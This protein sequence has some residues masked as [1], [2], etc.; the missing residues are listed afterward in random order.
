M[1]FEDARP[2]EQEVVVA[3]PE[4]APANNQSMWH[5]RIAR[6]SQG[7]RIMW[8]EPMNGRG[9]RFVQL[10]EATASTQSR[11]ALQGERERLNVLNLLAPLAQQFIETGNTTA[12]GGWRQRSYAREMGKEPGDVFAGFNFPVAAW[13]GELERLQRLRGLEDEAVRA[14]I[15]PGQAG[16]ANSVYEQEVL[17]NMFP[18]I[19]VRGNANSERAASVFVNRDL[20]QARVAAAE[21]WLTQNPDLSGFEQSWQPQAENLRRELVSRYGRQFA[22]ETGSRVGASVGAQGRRNNGM[23]PRRG[24]RRTYP[25][26]AVGEWDGQGWVQVQP[27]RGQ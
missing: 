15:R 24:Q 23:A 11:E 10:S 16:T 21:Q 4:A 20:Q 7:N 8:Q 13:G 6:D 2:E 5:G 3:Q 22:S 1:S 27:P 12:T 14:N 26:G 17:R 25:N 18:N 19:Q 9:G